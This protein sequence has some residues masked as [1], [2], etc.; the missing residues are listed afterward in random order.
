M[1]VMTP[2]TFNNEL[3]YLNKE[4]RLLRWLLIKHRDF[5]FGSD[6]WNE[7]DLTRP[8]FSS[9]KDDPM[10]GDF[11]DYTIILNDPDEGGGAFSKG[12][13][14]DDD[15]DDEDDGYKDSYSRDSKSPIIP[16]W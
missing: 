7:D 2:P 12:S 5:K 16:E 8:D 14:D 3:H 1:T 6:I 15:D 9:G 4:D 11:R 13:S 10:R